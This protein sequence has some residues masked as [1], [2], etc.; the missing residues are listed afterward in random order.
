MRF[1]DHAYTRIVRGLKVTLP[2]IALVLLSTMFMLSRKIDP[3]AALA[4]S[5][6]VFR[7][8][9]DRS[10]L[11]SPKHDGNTNSGKSMVITANSARPDPEVEGKTYGQV[12]NAVINLDNGEIMNVDADTGVVDEDQDLA[13]LSGNVHL[14]TSDGYDFKTSQLTSL[15]SKIEGESAGEVSGFGP[16]GTL[17]AGKM[18]VRTDDT[19]GDLHLLFTRGCYP[20]TARLM[21]KPTKL[22]KLL[23]KRKAQQ[24]CS[25]TANKIPMP[26]LTLVK[27]VIVMT[28]DVLVTQKLSAIASDKMTVMLDDGTALMTGRVKSLLRTNT[29]SKKEEDE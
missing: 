20:R 24:S 8:K 16:P 12:V 18:Y 15:L 25:A 19:T 11:S 13:I 10:Q 1:G 23:Q 6:R 2:L 9:I 29:N 5:D 14:T 7:D 3:T 26:R 28:G 21:R 22:L 27:E 17:D 4:L